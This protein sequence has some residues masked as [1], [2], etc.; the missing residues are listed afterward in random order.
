ML[1]LCAF[2]NPRRQVVDGRS[3]ILLDFACPSVKPSS[4]NEA[5]LEF[6]SGTI[7]I[8]E[9]DHAVQHVEGKFLADVRLEGGAIKIRNGT[10]VTITNRRVDTGIWLL[11]RLDARGEA[12][13]FAFTIDGDGH[14]FTGNYRKFHATSRILPGYTEVPTN[15]PAPPNRAAQEDRAPSQETQL[16]EYW[17][18]PSTGLMWAGK[19]N[20]KDVNWHKATKYCRDLR[21]AGYSDWR[22]ATLGELEG[23]YDKNANAPGRD[24]QGA[25]TWHV[26]GNLF[27]T[28][29]HGAAPN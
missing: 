3:T 12:R 24:G 9:E 17:V 4:V 7:G 21:L 28:G 23:I 29:N 26:K 10:R 2:S 14:I 20:G 16:R 22:L 18:D 19:D 25:S 11:S 27:L 1:E 8:D 13:Y 6:F 5:L 15:S